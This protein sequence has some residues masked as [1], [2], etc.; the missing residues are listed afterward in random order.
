VRLPRIRL[1]VRSLMAVVALAAVVCL[2][3]RI[4]VEGPKTH[5]Q[6]LELQYGSVQTRRSTAVEIY[7]S[8]GIAIGRALF[9]GIFASSGGGSS[10]AFE[11]N[12]RL[13]ER[14]A[15]LLVPTLLRMTHDPDAACRAS[16]VRALGTLATFYGSD[17][18]KREVWNRVVALTHD[19]DPSVRERR[20]RTEWHP[21]G[22]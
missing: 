14:R 17:S 12:H 10:Q 15:E 19:P 5:W 22:R 2:G 9:S 18:L 4:S 8:E 1:R 3:V 7:E 6:R 20:P 13:G 21:R 16:A 11:N